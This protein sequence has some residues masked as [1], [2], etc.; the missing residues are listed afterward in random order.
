[1]TAPTQHAYFWP[2][3]LAL[4]ALLAASPAHS[5][6][7]VGS[8]TP[9]SCTEAALDAA[10]T[11]GGAVS[12]DCGAAATSITL[13]AVKTVAADTSVD[14]GDKIILDGNDATTHFEVLGG[15]ELALIDLKLVQ[16]RGAYGSIENNGTLTLQGVTIEDCA[17]T[18]AGGAIANF[19]DMDVTHGVI[20]RNSAV[21][22]GGGIFNDGGDVSVGG[23]EISENNLLGSTGS[24]KGGGIFS[25]GGSLAVSGTAIRDNF[26]RDGGG[27][28]NEGPLDLFDVDIDANEVQFTGPADGGGL[29]HASGTGTIVASRISGNRSRSGY[30]GGVLVL[31]GAT[32]SIVDCELA[33]NDGVIGGAV[34]NAGTLDIVGSTL[35]DNTGSI[36]AVGNGVTGGSSGATL[37]LTNVTISNNST[38]SDVIFAADAG[39]ATL[40]FVTIAANSSG[41]GALRTGQAGTLAIRNSILANNEPKNCVNSLFAGSDGFN[42]SSDLTCGLADGGDRNG[43]AAKLR[44]LGD[45][46]GLTPTQLPLAGSPVIDAG[47]CS[48]GV[49]V[50]QRG[51]ERP[52]RDTCD[53]GAVE[54]EDSG[55][56]ST[57]TTTST[58]TLPQRECAD[59]VAFGIGTLV[60]ASDALAILSAAVGAIVCE[61]CVCDVD[62]SGSIAAT[63]ALLALRKAVGLSAP[64]NCPACN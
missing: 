18:T 29:I 23:G 14:G 1:M 15:V 22:A 58:T 62:G 30:A 33:E 24:E 38:L 4:V 13:T 39:T 25:S 46:G 47:S 51:I 64:L 41:E 12:F 48:Q 31:P 5:A 27:I 10:L 20:R 61:E 40:D 28:Y 2:A 45:Y 43:L 17:A 9:G 7:V 34:V 49:D 32:L 3:G 50:D 54:R 57:T 55:A 63:D 26:A 11:G 35:R 56:V 36:A 59:P 37:T 53:I 44:P 8:G 60:T 16:G 52:Q 6:G 21:T 19:S 42:L